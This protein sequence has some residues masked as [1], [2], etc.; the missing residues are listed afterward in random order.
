MF[1]MFLHTVRG[2]P[3]FKVFIWRTEAGQTAIDAHHN[4]HFIY[5]L[6]RTYAAAGSDYY[7]ANLEDQAKVAIY[8]YDTLGNIA[9][10]YMPVEQI[11]LGEDDIGADVPALGWR[12]GEAVKQTIDLADN[13]V[14]GSR[15][16]V[17]MG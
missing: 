9:E 15:L 17:E 5:E 14:S 1:I 7:D 16:D 4:I 2:K 11:S 10:N 13:P 8:L 3:Y 12:G 6:D